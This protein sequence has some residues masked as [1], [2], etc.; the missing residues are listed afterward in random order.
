MT[1]FLLG[2]V[3]ISIFCTV[4]SLVHSTWLI[5][6]CIANVVHRAQKWTKHAQNCTERAQKCTLWTKCTSHIMHWIGELKKSWMQGSIIDNA[7]QWRVANWR[8]K[9]FFHS[10]YL[11]YLYQSASTLCISVP[12]LPVP[13]YLTWAGCSSLYLSWVSEP[14]LPQW[15][16][17]ILLYLGWVNICVSYVSIGELNNLRC[18]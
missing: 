6:C 1:N 2:K 16:W 8:E 12:Q 10:V 18:V 5:G 14:I 13:M 15:T 4:E 3:N 9:R 17:C 7:V 11:N